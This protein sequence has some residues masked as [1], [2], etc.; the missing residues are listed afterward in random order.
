MTGLRISAAGFL[1]LCL[2]LFGVAA[3]AVS[4]GFA[5]TYPISFETNGFCGYWKV[6][7]TDPASPG[8]DHSACMQAE[9][10]SEAGYYF[11]QCKLWMPEGEYEWKIHSMQAA[12]I[13]FSVFA[14][15]SVAIKEPEAGLTASAAMTKSGARL[16]LLLN[17]IEVDPKGYSGVWGFERIGTSAIQPGCNEVRA[18]TIPMGARWLFTFGNKSVLID[19]NRQGALF[20]A[21]NES[22]T[23]VRNEPSQPGEIGFVTRKVTIT[24]HRDNPEI[25]WIVS[26]GEAGRPAPGART[27][28]LVVGKGYIIAAKLGGKDATGDFHLP[29]SCSPRPSEVVLKDRQTRFIV[30]Q[31]CP[32]ANP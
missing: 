27:I 11:G 21:V 14:D 15:G 3:P 32:G 30:E 17:H 31:I 29:V 25:P 16:D 1:A 8:P 19:Q 23:I 13:R 4:G 20:A 2:W 5:Q 28:S 24:P 22:L 18:N 9:P 10:K 6:V 26:E 7:S 12:R